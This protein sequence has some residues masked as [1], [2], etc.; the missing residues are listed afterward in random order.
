MIESQLCKLRGTI[1]TFVQ[2]GFCELNLRYD[3]QY[4]ALH[5][6]IVRAYSMFYLYEG[7]R[8]VTPLDA[9]RVNRTIFRNNYVH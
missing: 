7:H 6:N 9:A 4:S 1:D 5:R 3:Y 2:Y 8:S